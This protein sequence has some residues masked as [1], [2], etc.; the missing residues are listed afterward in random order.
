MQ[1]FIVDKDIVLIHSLVIYTVFICLTNIE[2]MR[3]P[4]PP[5]KKDYISKLLQQT[6]GRSPLWSTTRLLQGPPT[7]LPP[8]QP[9]GILHWAYSPHIH[10]VPHLPSEALWTSCCGRRAGHVSLGCAAAIQMHAYLWPPRSLPTLSVIIFELCAF[11]H[12]YLILAD[13]FWILG[14]FSLQMRCTTSIVGMQW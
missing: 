3:D 10:R 11:S 7:S 14:S 4:S 13:K 6:Y 8:S 1:C 5:S 12:L 9:A 2:I